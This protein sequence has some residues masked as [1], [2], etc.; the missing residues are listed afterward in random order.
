VFKIIYGKILKRLREINV[1]EK[2]F[3]LVGYLLENNTMKIFTQFWTDV[4]KKEFWQFTFSSK[5]KKLRFWAVL[6]LVG[7]AIYTCI[8][9]AQTVGWKIGGSAI[10]LGWLWL[11]FFQFYNTYYKVKYKLNHNM[12]Q[13]IKK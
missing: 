13:Y 12:S 11:N 6:L 9:D 7:Y 8:A 3:S 5:M 1:L 2:A 4:F 10:A